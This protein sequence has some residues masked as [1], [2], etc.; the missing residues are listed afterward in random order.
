MVISV[1]NKGNNYFIEVA[2]CKGDFF[3][4]FFGTFEI[5]NTKSGRIPHTIGAFTQ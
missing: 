2:R 1:P 3:E 4:S 5:W